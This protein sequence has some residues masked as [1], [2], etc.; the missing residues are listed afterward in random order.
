[1]YKGEEG[2]GIRVSFEGR[3]GGMVLGGGWKGACDPWREEITAGNKSSVQGC[4]SQMTD[5]DLAGN[6]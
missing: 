2:R 3:M 1:V 4:R 6:H 5:D